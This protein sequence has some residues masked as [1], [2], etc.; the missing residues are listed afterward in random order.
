[1]PTPVRLRVKVGEITK[2][3]RAEVQV[4]DPVFFFDNE[5][6]S[7]DTFC[8]NFAPLVASASTNYQKRTKD[9]GPYKIEVFV[10][11]AK[12][13]RRT[14][15]GTRR[16]TASRIQDVTASIYGYLAQRPELQLGKIA[17]TNWS[18][19]HAH[20]PE[21]STLTPPDTATFAQAQHRNAMLAKEKVEEE[22]EYDTVNVRIN[23]PREIP[24]AFSIQAFR[25]VMQSPNYSLLASKVFSSFVP[26]QEPDENVESLD[27]SSD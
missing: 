4:R 27:H 15:P 18:I 6:D 14:L 13:E 23:G 2:S 25:R 16:A 5:R 3:N 20:Q 12:K 22:S 19:S 7:Y 21:G 17:R 26:P 10:L 9:C 11:T 1:M 24:I 8:N